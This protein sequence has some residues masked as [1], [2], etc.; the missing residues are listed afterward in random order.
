MEVLNEDLLKQRY[1]TFLKRAKIAEQEGRYSEAVKYYLNASKEMLNLA[2]MATPAVQKIRLEKAKQCKARADKYQIV[3]KK[4]VVSS[5]KVSNSSQVSSNNKA[6]SQE[7][8]EGKL[9]QKA[10][11]PNIRFS[12]IAGLDDV[13]ETIMVRMIYPLKHR[14]LY[15]LYKKD[16]GGGVLL[17]GPPGTGKTMIAKAI[18][19]EVGASFYAVKG[20]DIVSKWVGESEKNIS[21]LFETARKDD[22][23]II[24][25]DEVDTLLGKRGEDIHNDKR[26]NEFL[27]QID[28]FVGK[29]PNLLLLGATNRPWDIDSAIMRSGRFSEKI[30]VELP[31]LKARKFMFNKNLKGIP[32]ESDIDI[33]YLAKESQGLSGADITEICDRAKVQPLLES[34]KMQEK[35]NSDYVALL[36]MK[37]I[38]QVMGQISSSCSQNELKRFEE[39]G[40]EFG[41]QV[42]NEITIQEKPKSVD[43]EL[44]DIIEKVQKPIN[45]TNDN[46]LTNYSNNRP[47]QTQNIA[48]NEVAKNNDDLE[49]ILATDTVKLLPGEKPKIEFYLSK[50]FES[51]YIKLNS[52]NYLC[53]KNIKN[54]STDE[55]NIEPG[56][57]TVEVFDTKKIASFEITFVKGM[58]ENDDFDF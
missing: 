17:F 57:Y 28:G 5:P 51:I 6:E 32:M 3:E 46:Q 8:D 16:T 23:A 47:T 49:L 10:E 30:Y 58:I 15:D 35:G 20:S 14:N 22:L 42:K 25:I 43:N 21:S 27:Q 41:I 29:N 54:W 45:S 48:N 26:V 4:I 19:C 39:F 11:I 34:V 31:D 40:K 38:K 12:D 24:F 52:H 9:W 44:E 13:K 1:E 53:K 33:N 37:H 36:S 50:D 2:K 7:N 56:K 18:A 55:I